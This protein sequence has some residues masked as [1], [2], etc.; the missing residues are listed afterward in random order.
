VPNKPSE[1]RMSTRKLPTTYDQAGEAL[2]GR[3]YRTIANNTGLYARTDSSVTLRLH[4]TDVITF[5]PDGALVLNSGGWSTVTTKQRINAVIRAH[6][7]NVYAEARVWYVAHRSGATFKFREGFV[8][9]P[10]K[11]R[12]HRREDHCTHPDQD[13]CDCDWCRGLLA[14]PDAR[15]EGRP[16]DTVFIV[17]ALTDSALAWLA[18]HT[19]GQWLGNGLAV[20]HRYVADLVAGLREHG[21]TVEAA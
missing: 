8:I 14:K 5:R 3:P 16:G 7:W 20:E 18:N 1:G 12:E 17:R 11:P 4:T 9:P 10:A 21:F 15:V 6:G 2:K 19:D 13:F